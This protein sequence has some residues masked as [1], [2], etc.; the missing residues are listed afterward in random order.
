MQRFEDYG[1]SQEVLNALE[2][3]GFEEPSD[4]QKL[5]IP[6]LLK[7]RTHLI[8][9]AQTGTGKTAAFGIPILE[10]LEAD[11]TVKALILAPTRELA[12]QVADEIY[13]L[14]GKKDIK[15]LAVYGGAS[16]EN[17]IK[18][19]K[20]GV[21]IVVGTPGRVMDLM[22]KKVLKVNN[23]DYFVLDE[24][25]EMLNMGFIEDIELILEETNDEK[26]M[27]FFSATI[28]KTIM[29]IAKKFMNDYKLL[30]VKKEELTTDLTE[31]I[32]YE[33][34]QEDKFEALCR[35]LDYTQNFY[36]IVFCRTKSEV[37]EVTNKLKAR[38]Y[39]AEC[40]HGDITQGLRQKALDLFKKKI[41]TILVATDVAARGIDVSN[42]THVINY[43]IPQEAE[44]YVHRIGRTGR[45]GHKGIAITFVTPREA[46][47][48]SQIKRVTKTDIKRETIPN[49]EEI[50]NA[51]KEALIAYIDEIIKEEDY[52]SY[53]ELADK[54]IEGRDPKQV[55]SSLLRHFYEDEFLPENYSEIEDVKVKID[56][57]TRL[58][59]ALGSKDGYNPGRLLDL[60]NK[61][62]KTPGRKVKDIK[63][64]DKYS[65]ITVPLQ[66]AE[67][68]MRA[69]NSK[70]DS[71]PLVEKA[72]GGQSGGGSSEGKRT[73]G[74]KSEGESKRRRK[75]DDKTSKKAKKSGDKK[76]SSKTK[77]K[78]KKTEKASAKKKKSK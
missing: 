63:I 59:I 54:L 4:I 26:K 66:E 71:K 15:V 44:S 28:P 36:G 35:V 46:R 70:K 73:R 72:T 78:S 13:S 27:L 33:V 55:L 11:K 50:L 31:Q 43:S 47:T 7:E 60:L 2:K 17:Q 76:V 56:D 21:D 25:D 48:L 8:G 1:L 5:V 77:E 24:A 6:E 20:S 41:L 65:F 49:V 14:K 53:E 68:I 75:S 22:R 19:L 45:A 40:I 74:R 67:Y 64:M 62:A 34:K 61:K 57:K 38:N 3:K 29:S 52:T 10:T 42:L 23:L 16:I 39:D 58:F 32:Y 18:K 30:K 51:K 12:N 37:D 69:L 9:Q